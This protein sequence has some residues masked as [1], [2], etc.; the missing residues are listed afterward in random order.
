MTGYALRQHL[1]M[2]LDHKTSQLQMLGTMGQEILRQQQ[3][4]EERV[5]GFESEEAEG[6]EEVGESTKD[7]FR[8]LDGAMKRW[9][10]HNDGMMRELGGKVR[11]SIY[12]HCM[13]S[14]TDTIAQA[15]DAPPIT[16]SIPEP[17]AAQSSLNR[18][19]RNAQH[20]ALDMEF[21]TEIGQNLLVEVR[22]LQTLLA[23]KEASIAKMQEE[24]DAS[25]T[26]REALVGA[27]RAAESS[28]GELT[29][30]FGEG[31]S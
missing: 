28:V 16:V 12:S 18:R 5:K 31:I 21:A 29:R 13:D 1:A 17:G 25:E 15:Q 7:K 19:Q 20:R 30:M 23:E 2:L 6:D 8:D 3:E 14:V 10:D 9:E 26:E 11:L 27:M 22:R 24:K 4:L